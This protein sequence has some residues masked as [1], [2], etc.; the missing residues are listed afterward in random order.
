MYQSLCSQLSCLIRAFSSEFVSCRCKSAGK[1]LGPGSWCQISIVQ[2]CTHPRIDLS[3][4]RTHVVWAGVLRAVW[5]LGGP[6]EQACTLPTSDN[7]LT[8]VDCGHA[9]HMA[10]FGHLAEDTCATIPWAWYDHQICSLVVGSLSLLLSVEAV[11][12][13]TLVHLQSHTTPLSLR[14]TPP[15]QCRSY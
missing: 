2:A 5:G 8:D 11:F 3:E 12:S 13:Q 9:R 7:V 4:Y 14:H 15:G 1:L 10:E 6:L